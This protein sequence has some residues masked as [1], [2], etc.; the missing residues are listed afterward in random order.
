MRASLNQQTTSKTPPTP[1]TLGIDVAQGALFSVGSPLS[2]ALLCLSHSMYP[3][4]RHGPRSP[5]QHG[6]SP[7]LP[8]LSLLLS[9]TLFPSHYVSCLEILHHA[10]GH[11]RVLGCRLK[12]T[13]SGP[14][15]P[16]G[17]LSG[18]EPPHVVRGWRGW[19]WNYQA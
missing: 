19:F 5:V 10:H 12:L 9:H 15:Q 13:A 14:L 1:C 2:W 16:R 11:G 8:L 6:L 4:C 17:G 3:G 7:E 18:P